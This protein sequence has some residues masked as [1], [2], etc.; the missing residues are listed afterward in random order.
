[1]YGNRRVSVGGCI[2]LDN[3]QGGSFCIKSSVELLKIDVS[4][5]VKWSNTR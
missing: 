4:E 1:V 5:N 3:I 2:C